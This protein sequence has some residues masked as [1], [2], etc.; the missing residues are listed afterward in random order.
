PNIFVSVVLLRGRVE[1]PEDPEMADP[2]KPAYRVGYCELTVPPRGR[3]LTVK[4][5]PGRPEYRPGQTAEVRVSVEKEGG[6]ARRAALTVWAVDAGVLGLTG[7][8]TPDP[9]ATFYAHGGLGVSTSESRSRLVGRRT[10]GTK[11]DRTGGGGGLEMGGPEVRRD[12]RALAVWRGDVVTDESGKASLSFT[13]PDSLTTYRL[14][15][16]ALAGAQEFG[17]GEVE[18]RVSKPVGLEPALPRF[19][20]P[21]DSARAGMVVRNRTKQAQQVEVSVTSLAVAPIELKGATKQTVSVPAGSSVEVG[22]GVVARQ[23]GEARL[24]FDAVTTGPGPERDALEVTLPV[25]A[26]LPAETVATFLATATRADEALTIPADVFPGT[27]GLEVNLAPTALGDVSQ[28]V[29]WLAD[30]PYGC[31]EQIASRLLGFLAARRL[32]EEYA[33]KE[34]KGESLAHWLESSTASLAKF[35]RP[36]GGFSFWTDGSWSYPVL[37]A[38][39]GWALSEAKRAGLKVDDAV[40]TRLGT[41]LSRSL[42]QDHWILGEPDGWTARVLI[43]FALGRLGHPE[44]AYNQTLFEQRSLR[45]S[46]WVRALLATTMLE[47]SHSDPRAAAL[48][49]EV[50]N[51]VTLE[52]RTA[53]LEEK[54]PDWGWWVFW[55]EPRGTAAA[56]MAYLARSPQDPTTDRLA[57]GLLDHLSRDRYHTTQDAAWMLQALA[58]YRERRES[59]PVSCVATATIGGNWLLKGNFNSARARGKSAKIAMDDLQNWAAAAPGRSLPLAVQ[60]QGTGL[61]HASALLSYTSRRSDRPPLAEG[62][63]LQRRFLDARGKPVTRAAAGSDVTVEITLSSTATTRFVAVEIPLPAGLEAVDP[64]LATTAHAA[65]AGPARNLE[66]GD[67]GEGDEGEEGVEGETETASG[68]GGEADEE[69]WWRPGFDHV[70]LRDDRIILYATELLPGRVTHLVKCRATTSG[71][72]LVAPAHA[73]EM[74]APEIFSTT[75]AGA[76]EVAPPEQK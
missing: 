20:R 68:E 59:E 1:A 22:F 34:I 37:S 46:F 67:E 17:S 57:R 12:F 21:E 8:R 13:L 44:P 29:R 66:A 51:A 62:M 50:G 53:R 54:E 71:S 3:R 39:V 19:L 58:T 72:F 2:G 35:Q 27:G 75:S 56:L 33:P 24:R 70:D 32:G 36:D 64:N 26:L 49:Q 4:L 30:Y 5:D 18:F 25:V 16:V 76:F 65:P 14:M 6:G 45:Q 42:R 10:Y 73:E 60:V 23:P 63:E 43:A 40:L 15:A 9:F 47:S 69:E 52:A 48:M 61:V 28:G 74:Y 41:Y 7:Y 55:S 31:S 11:G 38:H